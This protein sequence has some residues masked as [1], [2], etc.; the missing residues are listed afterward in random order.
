MNAA[1]VIVKLLTERAKAMLKSVGPSSPVSR[2]GNWQPGTHSEAGQTSEDAV[3]SESIPHPAIR[4]KDIYF[5]VL[6]SR[7]RLFLF[8]VFLCFGTFSQYSRADKKLY[9]QYNSGRTTENAQRW[10]S[11]DARHD[12]S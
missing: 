8:H 9:F 11:T 1:L 7:S 3:P 6:P 4:W 5:L 12:T 2:G 10:E